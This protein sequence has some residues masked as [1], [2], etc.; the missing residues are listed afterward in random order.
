MSSEYFYFNQGIRPAPG[1]PSQPDHTEKVTMWNLLRI[2]EETGISLTD[3]LAMDPAASVSGL[4]FHHPR[5]AYFAVG[6][7][8]KDQVQDYSARKNKPV[9]NIE[10]WLGTNLAYEVDDEN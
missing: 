8:Q 5:S 6:K 1:Y 9:A 10:K 3:S 7:V 4:Y 2:Q